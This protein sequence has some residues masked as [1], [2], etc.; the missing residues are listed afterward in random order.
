MSI[1]LFDVHLLVLLWAVHEH[2]AQKNHT[3]RDNGVDEERADRAKPS[4]VGRLA[5]EMNIN[6]IAI[7]VEAENRR[8]E[9]FQLLHNNL[10]LY[11]IYKLTSK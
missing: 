7:H 1:K 6:G 5:S 4:L 3:L 2:T 8:F 9:L 11:Y 10:D